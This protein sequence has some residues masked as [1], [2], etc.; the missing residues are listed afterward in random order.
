MVH[1]SDSE[2]IMTCNKVSSLTI[3]NGLN[4]TSLYDCS[5]NVLTCKLEEGNTPKEA[6]V[7]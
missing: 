1:N 7:I 3:L 6:V 5:T 2:G 4:F